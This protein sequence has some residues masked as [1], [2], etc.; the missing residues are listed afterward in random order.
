MVFRLAG[1][2][3]AFSL[4]ITGC[5]RKDFPVSRYEVDQPA[6]RFAACVYRDAQ[7]KLDAAEAVNQN[8]LDDPEEIQVTKHAAYGVVVWEVDVTRTDSG[9]TLATMRYHPGL[10]GWDKEALG[11][12]S[13]CAGGTPLRRV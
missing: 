2:A 13:T 5:T 12:M 1:T 7:R 8:R 11:A 10:M 3:L 4:I 9:G 6:S